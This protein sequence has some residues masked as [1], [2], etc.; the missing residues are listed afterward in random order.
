M[1]VAVGLQPT[2]QWPEKPARRGATPEPTS[3]SSP[4]SVAPRRRI[5]CLAEVRGLQPTAYHQKSLCDGLKGLMRP[6][7]FSAL[8]LRTPDSAPWIGPH[9][10]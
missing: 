1:M 7:A 3:R 8:S 6:Q 9:M 4:S 5:V 10:E 2:G